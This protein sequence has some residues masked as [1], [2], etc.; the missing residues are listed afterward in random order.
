MI[1]E[2]LGTHDE[3]VVELV[4]KIYFVGGKIMKKQEIL[5]LLE[6]TN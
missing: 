1:R 2:I 3:Y 5:L 6:T 4:Y